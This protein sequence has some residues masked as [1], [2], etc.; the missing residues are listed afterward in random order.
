MMFL[1]IAPVRLHT[2]NTMPGTEPANCVSH[3]YNSKT[4]V[5]SLGET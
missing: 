3:I 1:I 5:V 2:I 4:R